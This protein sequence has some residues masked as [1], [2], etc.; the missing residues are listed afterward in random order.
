MSRIAAAGAWLRRPEAR[1]AVFACVAALALLGLR[2]LWDHDEGRYTNIALQMLH[3]GDWLS[4]HRNDEIPHWSKP[5][6]TYW[7]IAASVGIFGADGFAARLPIALAYLLCTAL[8]GRLARVFA[9][10][11]EAVAAFAFAAMLLP[12]GASQ[13]IT[14]DMLLTAFAA[15]GALGWARLR[16]E[17]GGRGAQVLLG[18]GFGLAFLTKGPPALLPALALLAVDASTRQRRGPGL[19]HPAS[20]LP[21]AAV[22]LPWYVAVVLRHPGLFDYLLGSELLQRV[23]TDEFDRNGGALGWLVVYAPTLLLGALPWTPRLLRA[24]PA[25]PVRLRAWRTTDGRARDATAF[26]LAAWIAVPLAVF[27]LAR[28]RMPLYLLPLMVPL[29]LVVARQLPRLP[30]M[31]TMAAWLAVLLALK[32]AAAAWT[33]HKDASRWAA[34]IAARAPG[35]V[36]EVVFVEDMARYGLRLYLGRAVQ[37]EKISF[38]PVFDPG[39]VPDWDE[40]LDAELAEFDPLALWICREQ[41]WPRLRVLLERRGFVATP[42]GPPFE[43]RRMFRV[44]RPPVTAP[45]DAPPPR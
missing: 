18:L 9:P 15:L 28:S 43:R 45:A 22:A 31:R 38:H 30:R 2:G 23:A 39:Y 19:L 6:L 17:G 36:R 16:F 42:A 33:T 34:A 37:V 7:A 26:A 8:V 11:R 13:L 29:A 44:S 41:D 5:P 20:L 4:P 24:M 27:C 3:S 21:F 14:T 1:V 10:G 35:P 40:S 32:L 12:F 25:L